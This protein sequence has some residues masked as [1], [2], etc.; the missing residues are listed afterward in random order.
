MR[1]EIPE[2]LTRSEAAHHLRVSLTTITRLTSSGQLTAVHIGRA[3]RIP[4]ESL[5]AYIAGEQQQHAPG[6]LTAPDLGTWPPT[7]SMLSELDRIT[8]TESDR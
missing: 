4:A 6:Q 5:A 3:I 8:S 2:L 7:E 1:Q